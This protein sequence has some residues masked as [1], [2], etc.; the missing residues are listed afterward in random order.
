MSIQTELRRLAVADLLG[1]HYRRIVL[2]ASDRI[3]E[4]EREVERLRAAQQEGE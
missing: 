1:E 2:L 4:L 3:G